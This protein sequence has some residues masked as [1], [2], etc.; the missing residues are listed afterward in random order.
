MMAAQETLF[1]IIIPTYSR[2]AQL[3]SCLEA[4]ARQRLAMD[5]FEV[6]VVDDGSPA[7]P[8]AVVRQFSERLVISLIA[9]SHGG[10]AAARNQRRACHGQVSCLYG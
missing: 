6:V 10:P 5:S 9:A 8:E 7:P 1:S 4:L 3:A 2:P